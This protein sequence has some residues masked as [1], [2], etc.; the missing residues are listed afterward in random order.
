MNSFIAACD[1]PMRLNLPSMAMA[2]RLAH[3]I[4]KNRQ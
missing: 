3:V 1:Q 4:E 2:E